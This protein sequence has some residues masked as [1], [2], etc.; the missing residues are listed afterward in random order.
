MPAAFKQATAT[1]A[2]VACAKCRGSGLMLISPSRR[3]VHEHKVALAAAKHAGLPLPPKPAWRR[4]PCATCSGIGLQDGPAP[5]PLGS[6][7]PTVAIVGGGIGGAALALALQ[8][9]GV[10]VRI[11]ERD[12]CFDERAQGY[13]LTMQQGASALKQLG[14]PNEGVFSVAHHSF[15][16]DGRLIGSYGRAVHESTRGVGGN[17]RG[18]QQRRNAH[19]PRQVLRSSLLCRLAE[20]T[21]QWG[22]R[23]DRY[24]ADG[25]GVTL[26]FANGEQ[27]RTALLAGLQVGGVA[28]TRGYKRSGLAACAVATPHATLHAALLARG[29]GVGVEREGDK[30][31]RVGWG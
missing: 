2:A 15:L 13:G 26:H 21:V 17:G 5:P 31:A 1:R 4:V 10:A 8:Q 20:G 11:F 6:E 22:R 18:E 16:P 23:L 3:A 24:E 12:A 28:T 27:L 29:V 25:D 9:R 19:I 14:L 7:P 30:H